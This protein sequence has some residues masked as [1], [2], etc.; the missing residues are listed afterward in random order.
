MCKFTRRMPF[1]G[2]DSAVFAIT[3][4]RRLSASLTGRDRSLQRRRQ[5]SDLIPSGAPPTFA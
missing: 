1:A 4:G 3:R 5:A 2:I